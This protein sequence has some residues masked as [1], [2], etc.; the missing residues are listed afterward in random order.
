[1]PAPRVGDGVW[2]SG[3]LPQPNGKI[4]NIDWSGDKEILI[5]FYGGA[6]ET[7][8]WDQFDCFNEGLNQWIL[9]GIT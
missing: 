9:E 6:T 2:V 7:Y 1:M 4:A 3:A 8:E 5:H